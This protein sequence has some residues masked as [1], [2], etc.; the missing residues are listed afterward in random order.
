MLRTSGVF[1]AGVL[2]GV[3]VLGSL[4]WAVYGL[5]WSVRVY[6]YYVAEA[7]TGSAVGLFVGFLQK[8]RAGLVALTC[9]L[10][11]AYLQYVNRFSHPATRLRL[12]LLLLGTAIGLSMA[13][14]IAHTLSRTSTRVAVSHV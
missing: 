4:M 2:L 5:P 9:L 13:F 10:P 14:L 7:L 8:R 6:A 11:P 12:F 3:L 1:V